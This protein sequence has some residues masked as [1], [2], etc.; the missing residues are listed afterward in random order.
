M[1]DES[2]IDTRKLKERYEDVPSCPQGRREW[3]GV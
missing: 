2:V 1:F 3:S